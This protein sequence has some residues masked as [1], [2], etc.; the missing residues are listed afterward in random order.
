MTGFLGALTTFSTFS[1]EV[2]AMLQHG[3]YLLAF[4]TAGLHLIGSLAL[5]L[6]GMRM[7]GGWFPPTT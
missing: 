4:G 6:L 3:R 2:V 5:T 1:V 7:A